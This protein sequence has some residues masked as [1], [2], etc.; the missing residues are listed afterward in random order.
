[1]T[2]TAGLALFGGTF[3]PVHNCH[4]AVARA[5]IARR[6][7]SS[8]VFLI[9]G[10]PPHKQAEVDARH[11]LRMLELAIEHERGACVEG[12][13]ANVEL[14]IDARELQRTGPSYTVLTLEEYAREHP[15]APLFFIAGADNIPIL[16]KW[17]RIEMVLSLCT[18]V[19]VPRPGFPRTVTA[20]DLP[21]LTADALARINSNVLDTPPVELSSSTIRARLARGESVADL[22]PAPVAEYIRVHGLYAGTRRNKLS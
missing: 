6:K 21:F 11:R 20:R 15:N 1:M 2:S 10:S 8:V 14:K 12:G 3:D 4:L 19:L 16:H 17:Y 13:D 7:V 22:V 9:A 5:V 18:L